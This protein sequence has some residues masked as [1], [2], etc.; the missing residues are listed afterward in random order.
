MFVKNHTLDFASSDETRLL[1]I[2]LADVLVL[3]ARE[4][5]SGCLLFDADVSPTATGRARL[6][7]TRKFSTNR[8]VPPVRHRRKH[9][10]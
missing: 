3:A 1:E 10:A 4:R 2:I 7:L 9:H 6:K 5:A 8:A